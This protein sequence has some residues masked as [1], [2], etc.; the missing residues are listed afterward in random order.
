MKRMILPVLLFLP[1]LTACQSDVKIPDVPGGAHHASAGQAQIALTPAQAQEIGLATAVAAETPFEQA[2]VSTGQVEAANDREAHVFST[3]AGRALSVPMV[4]GQAVRQGQTLITLRS[5]QIGQME[6][7]L[8]QADLQN[9]S[10]IEQAEAQL[11]FS[12][13]G[14][15]RESILYQK[16]VSARVDY[17]T[18][19]TQYEKDLK[20][21][22]A[23]RRI[24]A[25][26]VDTAQKRMALYGGAPGLADR[27]IRTRQILPL[28]TITAPRSGVL[29]LRAI[30]PGEMVDPG[31]EIFTIADLHRVWLGGN[32][33]EQDIPKVHVGQPIKVTLDSMP[34]K[35]FDGKINYVGSIL[36]PSARTVEARGDVDNKDLALRPN[37]FARMSIALGSRKTLAIPSAALQKKGDSNFVYVEIH[38]NTFVERQVTA[39]ADNGQYTEITGGLKPGETI[40]VKGTM[41]LEGKANK[42]AE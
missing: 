19:A 34:G 20:N 30:N 14:Y 18:A 28:L 2:V 21:L 15:D 31:K 35:T 23:L 26:T 3:A 13:A 37:M 36:D 42:T 29:I 11:K 7:D 27:V 40:A 6:S 33:Y 16:Q 39:G 1:L 32:I 8:L 24:R 9:Q 41:A 38:P 4:A 5:D 12:K 22:Q 10:N 25:A 17:E